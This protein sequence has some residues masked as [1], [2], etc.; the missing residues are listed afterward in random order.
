MEGSLTASDESRHFYPP[1]QIAVAAIIGGPLAGGFL[2]RRNHLAFG[3]SKKAT[4]V[5]AVS[6]MV[7]VLAIVL[8]WLVPPRVPRSGFAFL[9]AAAYRWYAELAFA[10]AIALHRSEGWARQ[11][12]WQA[13][14]VS[15][16]FLVGTLLVM[17]LGLFI[18]SEHA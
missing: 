8:G 7:V 2:C 1:W 12:W 9:I 17:V 13:I 14:W 16:A 3:A 11:S 5:V 15:I 6:V 18:V 4:I 10:E